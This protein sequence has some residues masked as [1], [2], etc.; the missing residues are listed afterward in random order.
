M[1]EIIRQL[2]KREIPL[3]IDVATV[4]KLKDNVCHVQSLTSEK[5]FF[6]CR[7]NAIETNQGNR[8]KLTPIEGSTVVIGVFPNNEKAVILAVSEVLKLE[9]V[10]DDL[11]FIIDGTENKVSI[12]NETTSLKTLMKDL[13]T[14][15]KKLKVFT[16]A[17][18]SGTPLPTT[19][20][21]VEQFETNVTAL[22]K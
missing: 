22:L 13:A 14:I 8:F 19:I 16:P 2:I 7:L 18:P 20:T 1:E 4:K 21:A 3:V 11:E 5:D 12:K 10:K 6:K 17:G 9:Y 15:I